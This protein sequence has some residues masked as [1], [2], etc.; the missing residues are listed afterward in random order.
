MIKR[1][2]IPEIFVKNSEYTIVDDKENEKNLLIQK[3]NPLTSL[4]ESDITL[5][6]FKILDAYL[7]NINTQDKSS[8]YV[9]F[10]KGELE[11]LLGEHRLHQ[12]YLEE[13]LNHLFCAVTI[14]DERKKNKFVKIG[15]M[16]K[17][18]AVLED[19]GT[20]RVTLACTEEA[21]EYFFTPQKIGYFKYRLHNIV[22]LT[23]R[24]SYLM[25]LH[26]EQQLSYG[27]KNWRISIDDLQKVLSCNHVNTYKQYYRF[28]ELVL[29]KIHQEICTKCDIKYTYTAI[30]KGRKVTTVEIKITSYIPQ[31][32]ADENDP[33]LSDSAEDGPGGLHDL[34]NGDAGMK[35]EDSSAAALTPAPEIPQEYIAAYNGVL[36]QCRQ[37]FS[38]E[39]V[40]T[41]AAELE[42][43]PNNEL[44]EYGGNMTDGDK[45][46]ANRSLHLYRQVII[47]QQTMKNQE[48]SHPVQYLCSL[49]H[50]NVDYAPLNVVEQIVVG[51][52][53]AGMI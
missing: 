14:R 30:K 44:P 52:V 41:I 45:H 12:N 23:S 22:N 26:L 10:A 24:Y 48:V 39:E 4:S 34:P 32:I 49:I 11:E 8:R 9:T 43:K 46:K 3:A 17:A 47:L 2:N 5:A 1:K 53:L 31:Y 40:I 37:D 15:L 36:Q 38:L 7:A 20:W 51:R 21:M 42:A 13:R 19:D 6:E 18:E 50:N 29:K 25:F 16:S 33:Y 35:S 27:Y 28:N